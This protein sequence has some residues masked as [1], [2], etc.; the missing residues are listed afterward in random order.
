MLRLF[1]YITFICLPTVIK[2]QELGE[3]IFVGDSLQNG[4]PLE[5][6]SVRL[7]FDEGDSV[8]TVTDNNGFFLINHEQVSRIKLITIRSVGYE[9]KNINSLSQ[10]RHNRVFLKPRQIELEE[11]LVEH[12]KEPEKEVISLSDSTF[13]I[14]VSIKDILSTSLGFREING[15]LYYKGRRVSDLNVNG[16]DF[17]KLYGLGIYEI[18]PARLIENIEISRTDSISG[19]DDVNLNFSFKDNYSEGLFGNAIGGLGDEKRS[20]LAANIF[21]YNKRRQS[22][23]TFNRNNMNVQQTLSDLPAV[24]SFANKTN[25]N[26]TTLNLFHSQW[27]SDKI[28][29]QAALNGMFVGSRDDMTTFRNDFLSDIISENKSLVFDKAIN[30]NNSGIEL[31]YEISEDDELQLSSRFDVRRANRSQQS[32][33]AFTYLDQTQSDFLDK[34]LVRKDRGLNN[35]VSYRRKSSSTRNYYQFKAQFDVGINDVDEVSSR[36]IL[37]DST[38]LEEFKNQRLLRTTNTEFEGKYYVAVGKVSNFTLRGA[39]LNGNI[40]YRQKI[41]GSREEEYTAFFHESRL[42]FDVASHTRL[43][44]LT[45]DGSLKI[46]LYNRNSEVSLLKNHFYFDYYLNTSY[47][48]NNF[49]T[50]NFSLEREN[51]FPSPNQ[52]TNIDNTYDPLYQYI[53]NP[54]LIPEMR[55]RIAVSFTSNRFLNSSISLSSEVSQFKN[56]IGF[57]SVMDGELQ[58]GRLENIDGALDVK[59]QLSINSPL[60]KGN[61]STTFFLN[62]G[63]NVSLHN[64]ES[65]TIRNTNTGLSVNLSK[66]LGGNFGV[67]PSV[68]LLQ[69]KNYLSGSTSLTH[70]L[71]FREELS[72]R[73]G[74]VQIA[75]TSIVNYHVGYFNSDIVAASD[76]IVMYEFPK[77]RIDL[78]GGVFDA[79]NSYKANQ[80]YFGNN[81]EERRTVNTIGRYFM[82][83]LKKKF[84]F[85]GR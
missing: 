30:L 45:I 59:T 4:L 49:E 50:F 34:D 61:I 55:N 41:D 44:N 54:F 24:N 80:V 27:L 10:L 65:E 75:L 85:E 28:K 9:D 78:W 33:Y 12:F 76:V 47:L 31:K 19:S 64:G 15:Q 13:A 23:L 52:L 7:F 67:S 56:R 26:K 35:F 69:N 83:G 58:I 40:R 68:R 46:G 42:L 18:L 32:K 74:K 1:L 60:S 72:Y 6:A 21:A 73:I 11:V 8:F 51:R 81:F 20:I 39:F 82:I 36:T 77:Q 5:G 66:E 63:Q 37:N 14:N 43:N 2:S 29:F 62:R 3:R 71:V 17:F 38:F 16:D 79:F 53:G 48:P 84:G 70:Q 57:S 25:E 22:S